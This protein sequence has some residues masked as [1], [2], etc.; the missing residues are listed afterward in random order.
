MSEAEALNPAFYVLGFGGLVDSLVLLALFLW[1]RWVAIKHDTPVWRALIWLPVAGAIATA[2]G[3]GGTIWSLVRTFDAVAL[4]APELKA[5]A[6]AE[7]I[8]RAMVATAAGLG[9]GGSMLVGSIVAS[10][11]GTVRKRRDIEP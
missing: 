5:T 6:L 3:L 8:E 7:G 4:I 10:I 1:A 11:V 9:V 2:L